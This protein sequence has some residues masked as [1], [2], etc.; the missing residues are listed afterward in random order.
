MTVLSAL[1]TASYNG[2]TFSAE[3][4]TVGHD[5]KMVYDAA[6]RTVIAT[7]W[8]LQ[9]KDRRYG[10]SASDLD[11]TMASVRKALS[12][13][14]G[15]FVYSGRG[16]GGID[17]STGFSINV[18]TVK[19]TAWGPKP[20][21]LRER[22]VGGRFC[23][24][25]WQ[26]EFQIPDCD[27]AKYR[28]LPE[29]YNYTVDIDLGED[30]LERRT[31]NGI[32]TIPMTRISVGNRYVPDHVDRYF[33]MVVPALPLGYKRSNERRNISADRRTLT[34]SFTDEQLTH[35]WP[36][37]CIEE[38]SVEHSYANRTPFM[39]N[40]YIGTVSARYKIAM[41][42]PL[43]LGWWHFLDLLTDRIFGPKSEFAKRGLKT[44]LPMTLN[45]RE[46]LY[47]RTVTCSLAYVVTLPIPELFTGGMFQPMPNTNFRTWLTSVKVPY[48]P[49]GYAQTRLTGASDAIV[50]LCI[51]P[52]PELP[53]VQAIQPKEQKTRQLTT[54][55]KV[56]CPQPE[57]SWISRE[58]SL[59]V[60]IDNNIVAQQGL[61]TLKKLVAKPQKGTVTDGANAATGAQSPFEIVIAPPIII[62]QRSA[63][64][65]HVILVGHAVR[66]CHEIPE[67]I[68]KKVG[69]VEA[70]P[71]N[72][73]DREYFETKI[74]GNAGVP[75]YR[76]VWR[77][78]YVV[79]EQ[80]RSMKSVE[81]P[82]IPKTEE[83]QMKT[84]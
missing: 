46:N 78:R 43:E 59:L 40:V 66:A 35:P 57:D 74:V 53:P 19:D 13:P 27:G 14:G 32:L 60:E 6:D 45:V 54:A 55:M 26:V 69:D 52:G 28:F 16:S 31:V 47:D 33:E 75:I 65:Y 7:Q 63:P 71:D 15:A 5:M 44:V 72:R 29:S 76:A 4:Q 22:I 11:A 17:A 25:V 41:N 64:V 83:R 18:G 30:R 84:S 34:F 79:R 77:R 37:G 61:P 24:F 36:V 49:R 9:I 23:E 67:P 38:P 58:D 51:G 70:I 3:M 12:K 21:M 2:V 20:R 80:L 73:P 48:A 56:K 68:L 82:T 1:G 81:N 62:Q 10:S 39:F 50:D 42:Y 8:T